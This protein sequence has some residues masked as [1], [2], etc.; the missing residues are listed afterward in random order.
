M[1]RVKLK[2]FKAT[3]IGFGAA[4]AISLTIFSVVSVGAMCNTPLLNLSR[5]IVSQDFPF[6][7]NLTP[8]NP[9]NIGR[10]WT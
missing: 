7:N 10:I 9:E 6:V 1:P 8:I 5:I 4:C 2:T 3:P